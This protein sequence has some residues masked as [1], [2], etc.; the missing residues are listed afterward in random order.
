MR[1][2]PD[3]ATAIKRLTAEQFGPGA[4][5]RLFGS[6]LEDRARG[7]D[8]DLLV[9]VSDPIEEPALR[10]ARLAARISR[11][12]AGRRVDVLLAAP[13]LTEQAIHRIARAQGRLL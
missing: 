5:A 7:G 12:L 10:A 1:L 11:Y 9:D 13:N 3:Q 2:T 4:A 6:R 8:V